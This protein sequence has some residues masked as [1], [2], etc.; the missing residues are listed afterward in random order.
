[1]LP[2]ATKQ[3]NTCYRGPKF[4]NQGRF[5]ML[6]HMDKEI[7]LGLENL[8]AFLTYR[9]LKMFRALGQVVRF[10]VIVKTL[11]ICVICPAYGTDKTVLRGFTQSVKIR[12]MVR[13][14]TFDTFSSS[15]HYCLY[16]NWNRNLHLLEITCQMFRLFCICLQKR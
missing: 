10:K 11:Q 4:R 1:M 8:F 12:F 5:E 7:N 3:N 9:A 2:Q 15:V 14:F 13:K 16:H 6:S